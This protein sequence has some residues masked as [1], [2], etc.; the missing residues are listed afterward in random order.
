MLYS[1]IR[2]GERKIGVKSVEGLGIDG[3]FFRKEG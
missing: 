2:D 1:D 3:G